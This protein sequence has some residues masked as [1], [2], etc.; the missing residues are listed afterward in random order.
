MSI[1]SSGRTVHDRAGAAVL[2]T[3]ATVLMMVIRGYSHRVNVDNASFN[4]ALY[5]C[6]AEVSC[7]QYSA[8]CS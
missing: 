6:I 5:F 4:L 1:T 8:Y 3:G 7:S 2:G